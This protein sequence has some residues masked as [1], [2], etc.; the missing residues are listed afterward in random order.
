M[1]K[2]RG[3]ELAGSLEFWFRR[4]YQLPPTDPRFLSL[5]PEDIETEWFAYQY[6]ESGAGEEAED[7]DYADHVA[8]LEQKLGIPV[9]DDEFEDVIKDV[10]TAH[11]N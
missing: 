10:R 7:E 1:A 3:R 9:G 5:T 4:R 6:A 11:T 2:E 8:E